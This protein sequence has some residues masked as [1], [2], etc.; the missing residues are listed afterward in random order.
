ML[1]LAKKRLQSLT[2]YYDFSAELPH[3]PIKAE[4]LRLNLFLIDSF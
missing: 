1:D 3:L 2:G 4:R